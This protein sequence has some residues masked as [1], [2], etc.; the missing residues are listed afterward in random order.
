MLKSIVIAVGLIAVS[1][2]AWSCA[3]SQSEYRDP[4]PCDPDRAIREQ[5]EAIREQTESQSR[6]AYYAR[7]EMEYQQEETSR[8]TGAIQSQTM[9]GYP[10]Y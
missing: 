8:L 5:T 10:R 9:L 1:S 7:Q 6:D 4:L 2:P 3:T